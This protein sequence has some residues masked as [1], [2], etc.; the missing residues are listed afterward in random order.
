MAAEKS[1]TMNNGD[2]NALK[3]AMK[4]PIGET[5][6]LLLIFPA[7]QRDGEAKEVVPHL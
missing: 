3:S 4:G 6:A 2:W 5:K 7:I 1:K